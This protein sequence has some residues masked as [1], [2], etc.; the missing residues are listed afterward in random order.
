MSL[1]KVI[2]GHNDA[3][4]RVRRHG[5]SLLERS[6]GG[7][8]DVP[9]ALEGGLAGGFFAVFVP[10]EEKVDELL[11]AAADG[12][13]VPLSPPVD[14]ERAA[15][16]AAAIADLLRDGEG[17][18]LVR[19]TGELERC[20]DGGTVGAILHLEGA[21]PIE[22][23]LSNL[24]GWYARGLRSLGPVWS[25]PNAFAEGVPF[26]LPSSSDTGPGL[27]RAGRALVDACNRLG[28]LLDV[29]HLNA[30]GVRGVLRRSRAPVVAS[31]SNAHAICPAS[32]NLTD[33]QLRAIAA[34]G[35]LVGIV[36]NVLM[37][38]PDG[39][40]HTDTPLELV[41][42]HAEHLAETMGIDHVALGSDFDGGVIPDA[43][44]DVTGLPRVL[45]ALRAAGFDDEELAK[46]AHGNW[47]RVLRE[48][49]QG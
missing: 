49:W 2:D 36:F 40:L 4:L 28:I 21:E 29:S 7:H 6:P 44:G 14:P 43:I 25:R 26:R 17:L 22:P 37:L 9:R 23:D 5:G 35:G 24:E 11:A 31:H 18:R 3:L 27:T 34:S 16:E 15:L 39:R 38:R 10:G 1:P 20:L 12:E 32:R 45:E 41:A 48:V 13:D 42:R 46:I 19:T 30:R 47:L 8:V 33:E